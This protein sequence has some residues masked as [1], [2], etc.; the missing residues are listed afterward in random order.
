M[1]EKICK[2]PKQ[3]KKHKSKSYRVRCRRRGESFTACRLSTPHCFC[4][5]VQTASHKP[6]IQLSLLSPVSRN[7]SRFV[8][9]ERRHAP[10]P[11][12]RPLLTHWAPAG[13]RSLPPA[14]NL[15]EWRHLW[16][17]SCLFHHGDVARRLPSHLKN[18]T[19]FFDLMEISH[20]AEVGGG[21]GGSN[22]GKRGGGGASP[23]LCV[24]ETCAAVN[25][26][27]RLQLIN[28]SAADWV[29]DPST[30]G[31]EPG[32]RSFSS[33]AW[34]WLVDTL[35]TGLCRPDES[36]ATTEEKRTLDNEKQHRR[37]ATMMQTW[38]GEQ[39]TRLWYQQAADG[40]S[41]KY[42]SCSEGRAK[43]RLARLHK[44][45]ANQQLEIKMTRHSNVF[46]SKRFYVTVCFSIYRLN[47]YVAGGLK[48]QF[49]QKW[50]F[51]H[52]LL[53][54]RLMGSCVK[55]RSPGNISGASQQNGDSQLK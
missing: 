32:P 16:N 3:N 20:G 45:T 34:C 5:K 33:R 28:S 9:I 52:H 21:W 12:P 31:A 30:S 39:K 29:V 15:R 2:E 19:C 40:E 36:G 46:F 50:K 18:S 4:I 35:R 10:C 47:N 24:T 43:S 37:P 14:E 51:R 49:T 53:T 13:S 1:K 38:R 11:Q 23:Q 54:L 8:S 6:G 25:T 27:T 44:Q 26:S 22:W 42:R 55:S 17:P 48:E 41:L 7:G